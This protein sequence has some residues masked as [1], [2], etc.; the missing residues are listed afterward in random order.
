MIT[1]LENE[2]QSILCHFILPNRFPS[3]CVWFEL[4]YCNF[5]CGRNISEKFIWTHVQK[6]VYITI[7]FRQ[8]NT[9]KCSK[10][11]RAKKILLAAWTP[12]MFQ[13]VTQ[14]N[15]SGKEVVKSVLNLNRC[16]LRLKHR[17]GKTD[18]LSN[19]LGQ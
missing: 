15:S 17:S 4:V 18:S 5:Q 1:K 19:M 16:A 6:N 2:L 10:R 13:F 7:F 14:N 3:Y 9:Q 8:K 11:G 12:N